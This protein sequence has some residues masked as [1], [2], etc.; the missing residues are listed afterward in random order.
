M[1]TVFAATCLAYALLLAWGFT[2]AQ[3]ADLPTGQAA[4]SRLAAPGTHAILRHALAPG[5]GDPENFQL[6]DC[7]TQRNLDARGRAQ[8]RAIGAALRA[9]GITADRVLTSQWCRSAETAR[10]L[11]L[12]PVVEEPA[13]N[14]FFAD[15]STRSAQTEATRRLLA[16]LPREATA[17]LV[18]HQVNIT[19]LTGIY[20][21][22][23]EV[24]VIEVNEAGDVLPIGRFLLPPPS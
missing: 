20:P 19:A 16:A 21:R 3:A 17:I 23:G 12:G 9:A 11:G 5:T 2:S 14:S 6:G 7:S 24:V 22:S 4:L 13:L 1:R 15:R 8:S 18:S 10:L